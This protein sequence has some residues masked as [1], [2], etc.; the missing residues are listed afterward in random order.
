MNWIYRFFC[1]LCRVRWLL[2]AYALA[3][4]VLYSSLLPLWEGF[5]EPFHFGYVQ[6]LANGAGFPDP[7]TSRLSQEV[8]SSLLLAPAS[9][10]VK[11]NL[12]KLVSY[13]EFFSWPEC[14]RQQTR[15]KLNSID[16]N[17][18][19][20]P[21]DFVDYEGLQAPLA[22][23]LLALPERITA[24]FPLPA[25]VLMLR[26]VAGTC[27][28]ILLFLAAVRLVS[29]LEIRSPHGEAAIFCAFSSQMIWATLARVANDWLAVPLAVWLLVT[30]IDYAARPSVRGA[31]TMATVLSL[32]LLTKA[33]F[34]AF[35]PL[36]AVC[37]FCRRRLDLG[38]SFVL[39]LGLAGPWYVRNL[40]R[41]GTISGM[42]E[43][44]DGVNPAGAIR[45]LRARRLPVAIEAC[46]REALWT[47]N[48]S[49]RSFS[50]KTLRAC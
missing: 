15:R 2:L 23:A 34:L 10:S 25:R 22:Y 16:P 30:A 46:A 31:G 44:R 14:R 13:A 39:V 21:S 37:A 49:F 11:Q 17:L 48:N 29:Q 50:I 42:Q 5:D 18:R 38:V 27:G 26:I 4:V 24:K 43:L 45:D 12:P 47:G 19:W 28:A 9:L 8:E 3:N 1:H 40:E 20:N 7:R 33:Y 41:Y 6:S 35:I 32:G 36:L